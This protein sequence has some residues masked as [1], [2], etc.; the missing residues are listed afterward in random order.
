MNNFWE[1][2]HPLIPWQLSSLST[3]SV[4]AR[5][6]NNLYVE[7]IPLKKKNISWLSNIVEAE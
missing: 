6:L 4:L 1:T 2:R 7:K 5:L 3:N